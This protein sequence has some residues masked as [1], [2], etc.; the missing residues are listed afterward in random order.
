MTAR[1]RLVAVQ[2]QVELVVDDGEHLSPA[3]ASPITVPA[4]DLDKLPQII[5][6]GLDAYEA[7]A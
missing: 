5:R 2:V 4:V 7:D 3:T 6:D 1:A